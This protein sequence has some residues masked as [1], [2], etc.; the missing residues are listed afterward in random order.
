MTRILLLGGTGDALKIARRLTSQHFYSL[1]G[2]GKTPTDLHCQVRV[3]G[4]SNEKFN[5]A[6]GMAQFTA[7]QRI[8]LIIDATHPYAARISANAASAAQQSAIAYW[9]LRRPAWL[10]QA[11]D[12]WREVDDWL[13]LIDQ[14]AQFRRPFFTLGREP[15]AHLDNIP[16]AQFWTIRCL[17]T[18]IDTLQMN[19]GRAHIIGARGPF[20]IDNE[21]KL[22]VD[23]RFDV[24][25]SK[26]SGGDA[27]EA[28]LQI[29]REMQLPVL[30]LK[31]PALPPADREFS[32]IAELVAAL[33]SDALLAR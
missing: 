24:L 22:F 16:S 32:S 7:A 15:L 21:R 33:P 11:G 28:K 1:A 3:G 23:N 12:S 13:A 14:L 20:T 2:L 19:T 10:P 31:R 17:E 4:F 6:V 27:T 5:G 8:E 29:A 18:Q 25:I 26:N 30:M 9:A